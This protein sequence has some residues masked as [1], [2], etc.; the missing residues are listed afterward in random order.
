MIDNGSERPKCESTGKTRRGRPKK[1]PGY[2]REK[3]IQELLKEA[4]DLFKE[5]FDDRDERSPD[6]PSVYAVANAMG[7]SW[8]RTRKMLITAEVYSSEA[9]R[10]VQELAQQGKTISEICKI[11]GFRKAAVNSYLPY[12]KGIYNLEDAP[13]NA[14]KCRT[15]RKRNKACSDLIGHIGTE[16]ED[17]SLWDAIMAFENYPFQCTD[18]R[19]F[20]YSIKGETVCVGDLKITRD[21]VRDAFSK[22][23]QLQKKEGC[24]CRSEQLGCRGAEE[25]LAI[26]LRI[27]ACRIKI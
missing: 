11:T 21:E 18:G 27:G 10:K 20:R 15:F 1:K 22:V 6:A 9:S 4:V 12:E 17:A 24:V 23:I 13:V 5:P 3:S 7:T 26:F 14:D 19:R 8:V 2:D 16:Y 25:L